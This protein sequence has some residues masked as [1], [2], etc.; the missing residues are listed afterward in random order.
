MV[1]AQKQKYRQ[2]DKMESPEINA[3]SCENLIFDKGGENMQW[4]KDSLFKSGIEKT[5]QLRVKE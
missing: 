1:Q 3:H 4:R 2:W 5:R